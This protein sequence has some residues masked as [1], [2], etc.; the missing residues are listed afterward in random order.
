MAIAPTP[1]PGALWNALKIGGGALTV[2]GIAAVAGVFT[3]TGE[4]ASSHADVAWFSPFERTNTERFSTALE[5]L[6]HPAPRR[7]DLNGNTVFFS[8][9][10][11]LK[12]PEELLRDYQEEFVRQGVNDDVFT[13]SSPQHH[14]ARLLNALK[15]GLSPIAISKNHIALAG[16]LTRNRAD[17][18]EAL[19]DE[20]L[21]SENPHELFRAH[22]YIEISRD[23]SRRHTEITASWSDEAFDY[24]RM[25]PGN[26]I[27]QSFDAEVPSCPGCTRLSRFADDN[28]GAHQVDMTFISPAST[29]ELIAFYDRALPSRGWQLADSG[30]AIA[31][32]SELFELPSSAQTRRYRRADDLELTLVFEHD[33]RSGQNLIHASRSR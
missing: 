31:R 24:R 29:S 16:V 33:L 4:V 8:T 18:P 15:G 5:K 9:T 1:I 25:V 6:G 21:K 28:P 12:T 2:L 32:A 17:A 22:R 11:S 14:E 13:S 3:P 10:T 30:D 27:D 19:R 7:Y 23:P 26:R 20:F